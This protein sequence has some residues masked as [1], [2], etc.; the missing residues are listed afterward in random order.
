MSFTPDISVDSKDVVT[1][2]K[3]YF[4]NP[5]NQII[6]IYS[7]LYQGLGTPRD[8]ELLRKYMRTD[9]KGFIQDLLMSGLANPNFNDPDT[10]I[11]NIHKQAMIHT[12]LMQVDS[13]VNRNQAQTNKIDVATINSLL[14][15]NKPSDGKRFGLGGTEVRPSDNP[16]STEF[17]SEVPASLE[18][19]KDH[20][21]LSS[22]HIDS[23]NNS[24]DDSRSLI[25][26]KK[27]DSNE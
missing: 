21:T 7:K 10:V 18:Y 17:V 24:A 22:E 8:L 23:V 4:H 20:S 5:K 11:D 27:E 19:S 12:R 26:L 15:M 6:S 14:K 3:D 25:K 13:Q 1:P 16:S 9:Y 2:D